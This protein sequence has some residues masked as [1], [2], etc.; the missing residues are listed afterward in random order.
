[1]T[2]A[3]VLFFSLA[4]MASLALVPS[5]L[6]AP[7]ALATPGASAKPAVFHPHIGP[8]LGIFP[9]YS[10]KNGRLQLAQTGSQPLT[11][12]TYHGGQT[13]TGGVTVHTIFWT[14]GTNPFQGQ[15]PGA[16]HDYIG[17]VQQYLTDVATA[18]TG[19][20]GQTCTAAHCNVFTVEPQYGW[21]TT[22]GGIT[23][24][25]YTI[26]YGP[27]DSMIDTQPYPGDVGQP[28]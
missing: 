26:H 9:A 18:S 1:M 15:P 6:S 25:A 8:A 13:M 7:S 12:V 27:G 4:C 5:A 3:K 16:P 11:P 19:T 24:G 2:R 17:M 23:H 20:S 22:P 10:V 14:G 21:G 28:R